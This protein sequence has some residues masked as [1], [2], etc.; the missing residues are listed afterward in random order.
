VIF[1]TLAVVPTMLA[2]SWAGVDYA[3]ISPQVIGMF[4]FS[5]V[6]IAV[7]LF[8][9]ARSEEPI[10]PLWIFKNRIVSVSLVVIFITGFGM[11]S[12]I[13]FV[14][15]F[16]QGVLGASA[17]ASG[18]FLT[19][20]MLGMVAGSIISG[21]I[22][23]RTGGHYRIQGIFGLALMALGM[24]LLS[25]MTTETNYSTAVINI[26]LVGFGLG[27][28]TPIYIIA[29]Q[30]AVPYSVMGVATSSTAFFRQ[31][32]GAFGLAIFGSTMN[33][34]F[35]SQFIE[36][37]SAEAKDIISPEPLNTLAHNPQA[38]LS[39]EA[40]SELRSIFDNVGVHGA[41]LFEQ[42]IESLKS[43]LSSAVTQ[44]FLISF[45]IIIVAW[46]VNL[47][48]KEIPLRKQNV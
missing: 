43:A 10:I 46:I 31:I 38:L 1:L 33:N 6:M 36:G 20:M 41:A 12:A 24:G 2:L 8:I 11:F 7:F 26:I 47:F 34:R 9:E 4:V 45:A 17:T 18:S 40:E 22:L 3:W 19:P 39:T 29:V 32:G 30:N 37:L 28:T 42:V 25:T 23:A 21:Q 14:P 35:A 15:L 5:V 27:N 13:I 48:V 16:F 44:V